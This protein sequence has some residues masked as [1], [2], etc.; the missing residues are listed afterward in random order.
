MGYNLNHTFSPPLVKPCI[1]SRIPMTEEHLH[2]QLIL[3]LQG[4]SV[5]RVILVLYKFT[6][7]TVF[8]P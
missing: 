1:Q 3:P 7:Y 5:G 6:Y 2:G 4:D 8:I